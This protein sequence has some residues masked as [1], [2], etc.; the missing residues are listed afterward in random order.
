MKVW[1]FLLSLFFSLSIPPFATFSSIYINLAEFIL[2]S[3]SL[4]LFIYGLTKFSKRFILSSLSLFVCYQLHIAY[5]SLSASK[6]RNIIFF[7]LR[8]NYAAAFTDGKETVL[9]TDLKETDKSY[10]F[11]LNLH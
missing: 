11:L 6:Q 7:S 3:S 5:D 8:K 10:I 1:L 2:L 9:V 4:G